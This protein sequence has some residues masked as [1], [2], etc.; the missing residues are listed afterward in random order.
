M[1]Q[2]FGTVDTNISGVT[3]P[4]LTLPVINFPID[5][6]VKVDNSKEVVITNITTP[7]DQPESIRFG[8]SEISDIYK[9][10]G[11]NTDQIIG[12]KNGLSVLAQLNTTLKVTDDTSATVLGYLPISAHIVLKVPKSG[13]IT[14]DVL[15]SVISR[16]VG[17]CYNEGKFNLMTLTRGAITPK[18]L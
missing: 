13:Y 5:Y 16:L 1:K 8:Y 6:R 4:S 9:N 17:T 3:P 15:K 14:D 12:S 18:G 11:L 7:L 2:T 10:A